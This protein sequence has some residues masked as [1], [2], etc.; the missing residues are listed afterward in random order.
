M[1]TVERLSNQLVA[2]L[3][4]SPLHSVLSRRVML[5][6]FAG[7]RSGKTYTTPVSYIR[8][9]NTVTCFTRARWWANL[10]GGARVTLR[11]EGRNHPGTAEVIRAHPDAIA[12]ALDAFLRRLPGDAQFWK[13]SLD[14]QRQPLPA[15][16]ERAS[17]RPA[18]TLIRVHL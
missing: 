13:V 12:A 15:D 1:K 5:I 6:T 18:M 3:L 7:R 2:L 14:A 10:T 11:L 17:Q 8:D 16:I 9:G 4:C